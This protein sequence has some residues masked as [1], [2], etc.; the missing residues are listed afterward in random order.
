MLP[1]GPRPTT[2]ART[3][4][5]APSASQ[6]HEGQPDRRRDSGLGEANV[7]GPVDAARLARRRT[8]RSRP[9]RRPAGARRRQRS[10]AGAG[11][12]RASPRGRRGPRTRSRRGST[13]RVKRF[14]GESGHGHR[15]RDAD[16][17][18]VAGGVGDQATAAPPGFGPASSGAT[19]RGSTL[20]TSPQFE[21]VSTAPAAR[22]RT[23]GR[24]PRG[25][26]GS[27]RSGS[28]RTDRRAR[29]G[30]SGGGPSGRP[31]RRRARSRRPAGPPRRRP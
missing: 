28:C 6:R 31:A 3:T 15:L 2:I 13:P 26:R 22:G 23:S 5:E 11:R 9:R 17:V 8:S 12:W 14:G 16:Y 20:R 10:W 25:R 27:A 18:R 30:G 4:S 7:V 29:R 24:S 1:H 21:H 19:A